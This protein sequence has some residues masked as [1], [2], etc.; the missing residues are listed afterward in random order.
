MDKHAE[1]LGRP[2]VFG[3]VLGL[4]NEEIIFLIEYTIRME[5]QKENPRS[6]VA[7]EENARRPCVIWLSKKTHGQGSDT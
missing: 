4:C 6:R 5:C 3:F 7:F 1:R 2:R